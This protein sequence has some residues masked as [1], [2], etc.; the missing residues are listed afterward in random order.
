[1]KIRRIPSA[2]AAL[3]LLTGALVLSGAHLEWPALSHAHAIYLEKPAPAPAPK[4]IADVKNFGEAFSQLSEQMSPTVVNIYTKSGFK[5]QAMKSNLPPELEDQ[6]RNYFGMGGLPMMQIPQMKVEALGSGFVINAE[7]GYI[8]TNAHV[9]KQNGQMADE[10][11][12]K[13]IG[14]D[15]SKGHAAKVVGADEISDV[16]LLKLVEK[17]AGLKAAALGDSSKSKVGEWVLAIGNPYGHTHTVTQGIISALGRNLDGVRSEF[18]QTSASINPGNSGGPLINMNGEVIG[19]NS[20]IDPRAQNI[21]FAIPINTAKE[22]IG[23]LVD[24]GHV[25]SP[26]PRAHFLGAAQSDDE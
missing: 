9:V 23:Q 8:V 3:G 22:V 12:V 2:L 19:I 18:L 21:G 6:F 7:E 10:I 20:V 16:A 4:A 24:G 11:M 17:K 15:S 26:R 1:M 5:P 25:H 13:F 14:E